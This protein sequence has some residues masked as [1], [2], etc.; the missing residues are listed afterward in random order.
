MNS[1]TLSP[2]KQALLALEEMRAAAEERERSR[3]EPIAIIGMACRVPGAPDASSFWDVL[4][5]G[6]DAVS[7]IPKTRWDVDAL[8]D[9]DPD[10]PGKMSIK[11]AGLL[12]RID[13]F[14]PEFFGISPREALSMDPQQ[15]LLLEVAWE[16]IENAGQSPSQLAQTLTGVFVGITG[17]E[18]AQMF[19]KARDLK[20]FD[21]YFASGI[22]R[23]VVAGRIS[24]VLGLA[25][26]E[27]FDR[28]GVLLVARRDPLRRV[29]TCAPA[30]AGRLSPGA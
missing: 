28:H 15:R 27:P 11:R 25:R 23:S 2:V 21:M 24:Y 12:D 26:P 10:K 8:Y 18:F 1:P 29:C 9:P 30:N 20:R 4:D 17:D 3:T 5:G 14:E 19:H 16:A 22:A 13:A 7:E 6:R